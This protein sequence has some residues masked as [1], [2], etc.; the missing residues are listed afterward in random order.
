MLFCS[1]IAVNGEVSKSLIGERFKVVGTKLTFASV[2]ASQNIEC[3]V[4]PVE[5]LMIKVC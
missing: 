3:I 5:Q 2:C 4:Q 1:L